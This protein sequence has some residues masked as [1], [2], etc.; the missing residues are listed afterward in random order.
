M[1]ALHLRCRE[2]F[3]HREAYSFSDML[4]ST[5]LPGRATFQLLALRGAAVS[6]LKL[7]SPQKN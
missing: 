1:P 2:M 7:L 4:S 5:L 3:V 6:C